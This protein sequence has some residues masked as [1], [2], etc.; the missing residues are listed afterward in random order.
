[1]KFI[2]L[3]SSKFALPT[4][5]FL[6]GYGGLLL[7]VT[8]M[9]HPAGR[10]LKLTPT[11]VAEFAKMKGLRLLETD[12]INDSKYVE[13]IKGMDI[14]LAIVASFGQLLKNDLLSSLKIGF[15]NVHASLLPKYRGAAPIQ[16]ALLDGI[17]KTGITIFKIEK[18]LDTGK[19]AIMDE[20]TI[21][22]FDTFDSLSEKLSHL[23]ASLVKRFLDDPN[24]PLKDQKGE[25]S[26]A[27][28]ISS[29]ET[30]IDWS[31]SARDVGNTIRAFDSTPGARTLF[32]G[33]IVKIFGFK[34]TEDIKGKAGE[35]LKINSS[36]LIGCGDMAIRIER[37]QFPSK[38]VMTFEEAKNGR[39]IDT[40]H[41]F[42]L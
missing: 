19:I 21:D 18:G 13:M 6:A 15:F 12:D 17:E 4:L 10:K 32:N 16:R 39:K 3:G 27:K 23:G 24:I 1:L 28:K 7:V 11:P 20:S 8:Q 9:P 2:F 30:F 37:I 31:K 36:A 34:G 26:Y 42:G 22:R 25:I 5:E 29:E 35:L 14:D 33:E 41:L 40:G 38:R